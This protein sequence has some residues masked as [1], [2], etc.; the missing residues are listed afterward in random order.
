[1]IIRAMKFQMKKEEQISINLTE[2]PIERM[3]A[4]RATSLVLNTIVKSRYKMLP[5]AGYVDPES[6]LASERGRVEAP[7]EAR[8]STISLLTSHSPGSALHEM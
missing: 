8:K 2:F 7:T 5:Y 4:T 3:I 6:T 1:M